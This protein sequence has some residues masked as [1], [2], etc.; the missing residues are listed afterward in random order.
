MQVCCS[1]YDSLSQS[2]TMHEVALSR[3]A[4]WLLV[5]LSIG[6]VC[7]CLPTY[8]P[9]LSSRKSIV[10]S[11]KGWCSSVGSLLG[12]WNRSSASDSKGQSSN[13]D[14]QSRPRGHHR[15]LSDGGDKVVLTQ[16]VGG[17]PFLFDQTSIER[18]YP[19]NAIRVRNDIE[20]GWQGVHCVS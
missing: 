18:D 8:A 7:A 16:V 20:L 5:Q 4:V 11:L 17:G 19:L 13:S 15:N 10:T 6:V 12:R 14:H 3:M 1:F 9:L 2:N